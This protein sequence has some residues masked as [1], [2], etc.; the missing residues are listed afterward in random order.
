MT[1]IDHNNY[2][3]Q[4]IATA[5]DLNQNETD[6]ENFFAKMITEIIGYGIVTS[7]TITPNGTPDNTILIP[8]LTAYTNTGNRVYTAN[9]SRILVYGTFGPE[10]AL[11]GFTLTG[12]NLTPITNN[13][14]IG[15]NTPINLPSA[16]NEMWVSLFLYFDRLG[17]DPRVDGFGNPIFFRISDSFKFYLVQGTPAAIGLA[18][19]PTLPGDN[20]LLLGDIYL[21]DTTT[22]ISGPN[23]D[24]S[25]KQ[26][27]TRIPF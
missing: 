23:L 21:R 2:Y 5:S 7:V 11:D 20:S 13:P 17:S 3:F 22:D 9:Q 19:K 4:D 10:Q 18:I 27:F 6:L 16:G 8:V 26:G 15:N 14:L 25:R 1:T 24:F 12:K